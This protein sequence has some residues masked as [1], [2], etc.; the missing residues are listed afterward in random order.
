MAPQAAELLEQQIFEMKLEMK[1][2]M[3]LSVP[4]T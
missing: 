4:L 1:H 2:L 3:A